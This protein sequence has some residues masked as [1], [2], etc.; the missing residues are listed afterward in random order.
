M[1]FGGATVI[2][3]GP[4]AEVTVVSGEAVVWTQGGLFRESIE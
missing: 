4:A 1:G 3:T 2:G